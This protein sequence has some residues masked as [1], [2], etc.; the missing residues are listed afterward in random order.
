M[1]D[2]VPVE[3]Q[4]DCETGKGYNHSEDSVESALCGYLLDKARFRG[5]SPEG[6]TGCAGRAVLVCAIHAQE[7]SFL[8]MEKST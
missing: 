6:M 7:R 3:H 4:T 5:E 1:A 8:A 2:P